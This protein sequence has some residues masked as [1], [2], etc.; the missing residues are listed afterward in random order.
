VAKI[1]RPDGGKVYE[2]LSDKEKAFESDAA[3]W[4]RMKE[5]YYADKG[6]WKAWLPF[7]G[8]TSVREV[9]VRM[10]YTYFWE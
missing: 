7:Y 9:E 10:T 5:V 1:P 4:A 2:K 6:E 3:I 8:P